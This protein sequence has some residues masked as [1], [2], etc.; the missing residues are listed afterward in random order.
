MFPDGQSRAFA[1]EV[2]YRFGVDEEEWDLAFVGGIGRPSIG[3]GGVV[4]FPRLGCAESSSQD[5]IGDRL[6]LG[7]QD[8][9]LALFKRLA[10]AYSGRGR[11]LTYIDHL[12]SMSL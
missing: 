9:Y 7:V 8:R 1:V 10:R 12:R 6:V 4:D 11:P 5:A 2:I 3:D